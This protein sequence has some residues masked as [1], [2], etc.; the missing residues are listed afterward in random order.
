[1]DSTIFGMLNKLTGK[2]VVDGDELN[3]VLRN[4][5]DGFIEAAE[6]AR[7]LS[8]FNKSLADFG[9]EE[10]FDT[11]DPKLSNRILTKHRGR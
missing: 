5:E 8:L 3:K 11:Q 2:S 10:D 7:D 9:I 4:Y 6:L 1:M